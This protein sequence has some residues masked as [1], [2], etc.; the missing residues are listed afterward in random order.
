MPNRAKVNSAIVQCRTRVV[1]LRT[2]NKELNEAL[3]AICDVANAVY[4]P[5][6]CMAERLQLLFGSNLGADSDHERPT[7]T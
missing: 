4:L 2:V 7:S 1:P 3:A 5:R 6:S